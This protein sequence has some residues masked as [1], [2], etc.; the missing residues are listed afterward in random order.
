V[1]H[2]KLITIFFCS[3]ADSGHGAQTPDKDGDEKD[4]F[5][6]VIFPIDFRKRG[7]I[8]DDDMH[9]LMVRLLP[10]GCRLTALFDVRI[11]SSFSSSLSF[12]PAVLQQSY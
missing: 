2:S 6:E 8:L 4:G 7:H 9:A 1:V 10:V 3:F 12:F 5:D 11:L